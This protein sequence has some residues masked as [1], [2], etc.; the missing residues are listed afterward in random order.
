MPRLRV[1][2]V[3]FVDQEPQPGIIECVFRDAEDQ[4]HTIID[5]IPMFTTAALGA[6]SNYPQPAEV[7]CGLLERITASDNRRL[8]RISIVEPYG[9]ESTDGKSEFVVDGAYL[10]D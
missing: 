7:V 5:K 9:M 3:R 10:S 4:T 1:Q 2:I 6:D 8:A